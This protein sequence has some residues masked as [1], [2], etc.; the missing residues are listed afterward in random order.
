MNPQRLSSLAVNQFYLSILYERPLVES[1]LERPC[2]K[3]SV[4]AQLLETKFH[5]FFHFCHQVIWI[6]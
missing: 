3:K 4:L 1:L 5:F 6:Q 2:T